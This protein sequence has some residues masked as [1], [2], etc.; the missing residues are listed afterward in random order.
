MEWKGHKFALLNFCKM[1][2][3]AIVLLLCGVFF[4]CPAQVRVYPDDIL[5]P[6]KEMNGVNNGPIFAKKAQSKGNDIYYRNAR[7]PYARIHDAYL[8][9]AY[10]GDHTVD[11]TAV[12]PDF[13]KN[14]DDPKAYDFAVTDKYLST[15]VAVGTKV[16]F[17]LGESI[18][19]R[20]KKY[21]VWAP[22]DF[23]KWARI[24]EHII[25][26]YN[27]G[28]NNGFHYD[29]EYW[30]IWNEPDLDREEKNWRYAPRN[31]GGSQEQFF[32]FY[33]TAAKH[34][35]KCFPDLKIGGPALCE[36]LEWAEEFIAE[37]ARRKVPMD[38]FSWHI[39]TNTPEKLVAFGQSLRKILDANGYEGIE[40]ICDEW[41]YLR[42]WNVDYVYTLQAV[43]S[44]KGAA[45]NAACFT[46]AQSSDISKLLYYDARPNTAL[47]GLFSFTTYRPLPGYYP[48]YFWSKLSSCGTQIRTESDEPD[49]YSVAARSADDERMVLMLT[50]YNDDDNVSAFKSVSVDLGGIIAD[51]EITSLA[52]D[53]FRLATE[54]PLV[55]KDGKVQVDMLPCSVFLLY[56]K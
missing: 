18:D 21:N 1:K 20:V 51:G 54:V 8:C 25:L 19:H 56:I 6:I 31:W 36:S 27:E 9:H 42:N 26:H 40:S 17:R 37:M 55:V 28:W 34:L 47:N 45:F 23:G 49:I 2:R 13:S 4:V 39:Y 7:I 29:I 12:F 16:F 30:E 5:G 38:F 35:H 24:C 46:L 53:E 15:I 22:K 3:I 14:P 50:R 52:I 32:D 44:H 43:A 11:I 41:N 48:F 10:G 33:E